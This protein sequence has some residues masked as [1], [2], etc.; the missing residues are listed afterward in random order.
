MVSNID[1]AWSRA[2]LPQVARNSTFVPEVGISGPPSMNLGSLGY[3]RHPRR[4]MMQS[5]G[6]GTLVTSFPFLCI[7]RLWCGKYRTA[8]RRDGRNIW[9]VVGR[10]GRLCAH[11]RHETSVRAFAFSSAGH[12][13][14]YHGAAR[15]P[16]VGLPDDFFGCLLL[17]EPNVWATC[18]RCGGTGDWL[19]SGG[20]LA[21]KHAGWG[22]LNK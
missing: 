5:F 3:R 1:G 12:K 13:R 22:G 18:A 10:P 14:T 16:R 15:G 6:V 8:S 21:M 7:Q 9:V 4:L 11:S 19:A 20:T 17:L 2:V